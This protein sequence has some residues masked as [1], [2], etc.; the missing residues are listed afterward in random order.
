TSHQQ[1]LN[2]MHNEDIRSLSKVR[3][4]ILHIDKTKHTFAGHL[5]RRDDDR[6]RTTSVLGSTRE[7]TASWLTSSTMAILSCSQKQYLRS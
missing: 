3:D 7:E 2:R 4:I 1:R 5:I 6:W